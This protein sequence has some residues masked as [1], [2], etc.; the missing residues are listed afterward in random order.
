VLPGNFAAYD[1]RGRPADGAAN[2]RGGNE[3]LDVEP[4]DANMDVIGTDHGGVM[5][6]GRIVPGLSRIGWWNGARLIA[7]VSLLAAA[8]AVYSLGQPAPTQAGVPFPNDPATAC[9]GSTSELRGGQTLSFDWHPLV[10]VD[11]PSGSAVVLGSG[12]DAEICVVSRLQDGTLGP[13]L[14]GVGRLDPAAASSLTLDSGMSF[15]QV[16]EDIAYGRVPTGTTRLIVGDGSTPGLAAT[17]A[18]GYWLTW[19]PA[20]ATIV[21]LDAFDA[22]G[23][24]LRQLD[25]PDGIPF[26][27]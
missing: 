24:I 5:T 8:G 9:P 22:N 26:G 25:D 21:E 6:A 18:N 7:A 27:S 14:S 15:S 2:Q 3:W 20:P 1:V 4:G 17:V 10:E 11:R 19:L 12:L 23:R 16:G 13:A